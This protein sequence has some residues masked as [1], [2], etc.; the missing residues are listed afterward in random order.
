M[1]S[2][3]RPASAFSPWPEEGLRQHKLQPGPSNFGDDTSPSF[4]GDPQADSE[5][6]S[7]PKPQQSIGGIFRRVSFIV[8]VCRLMRYVVSILGD[9]VCQRTFQV[10]LLI[11]CMQTALVFSAHAFVI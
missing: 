2:G 7:I 5:T 9:A 1:C 4:A 11:L 6:V 10:I 8:T 3:P